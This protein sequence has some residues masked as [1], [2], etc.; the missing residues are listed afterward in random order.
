MTLGIANE[1][2]DGGPAPYN[3]RRGSLSGRVRGNF[4]T[5]LLDFLGINLVWKF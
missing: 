5:N 3:I 1:V 2:F 4:S